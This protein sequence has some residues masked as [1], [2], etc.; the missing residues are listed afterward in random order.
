MSSWF[1]CSTLLTLATVLGIASIA[2]CTPQEMASGD[3]VNTMS[4]MQEG[5]LVA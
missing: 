1:R 2:G 5:S 3:E 4:G